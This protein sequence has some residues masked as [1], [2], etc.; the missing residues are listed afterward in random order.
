MNTFETF[1][2]IVFMLLATLGVVGTFV[3]CLRPLS[4][5]KRFA[6][7]FG[8]DFQKL[9]TTT[10]DTKW[11]KRFFQYFGSL[12]LGANFFAIFSAWMAFHDHVA[13]AWW[14]LIYYPLMF[15]WHLLITKKVMKEK[16]V[17]LVFLLLSI[18]ALALT[19][20]IALF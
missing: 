6:D 9:N 15:L 11:L 12:M 5:F 8:V 3:Y 20:Q 19:W 10:N 4:T 17:Q 14:S 16:I 1:A 2:F 7:S 13:L 18:L